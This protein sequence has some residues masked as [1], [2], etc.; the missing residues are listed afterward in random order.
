MLNEQLN[1]CSKN[2]KPLVADTTKFVTLGSLE[3][4]VEG[5][6][7]SGKV[8]AK[9]VSRP[10]IEKKVNLYANSFLIMLLISP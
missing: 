5:T 9:I 4:L 3:S 6:Q 1:G 7:V 10:R 8:L 2:D